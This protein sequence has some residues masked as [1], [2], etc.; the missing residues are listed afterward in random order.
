MCEET[1]ICSNK[2]CTHNGKPQPISNFSKNKNCKDGLNQWCKT[3]VNAYRKKYHED[4]KEKENTYDKN[5]QKENA[6]DRRKK[7]KKWEESPAKYDTYFEKISK[8]E[9]CQRDPDNFELIQ[10]KCK[11]CGNWFNPTNKQIENKL[12]KI[13][14]HG[15]GENNLYCSGACKRSCPTYRQRI[16]PKGFKENTSREVQPELRKMVFIRDNW[17]CQKC[18]KSKKD[19]PELVLHCH[20]KYPLNEDPVGSADMDNCIT[21][22]ADCHKWIHMNVPGCGYAEMKC[23][24]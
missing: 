18:G 19:I 15:T 16:Y 3:C 24:E 9:E 12:D 4:N 5:Y 2:K 6:E 21:F 20:H 7:K 23:S 17:I 10:V 14:G 22:C 13:N 8:Y 11:Y 1:K